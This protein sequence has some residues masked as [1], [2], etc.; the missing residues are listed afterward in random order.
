MHLNRM[1]SR[2]Q[3]SSAKPAQNCKTTQKTPTGPDNAKPYLITVYIPSI[4]RESVLFPP[5]QG[6]K[7]TPSPS[8]DSSQKNTDFFIFSVLFSPISPFLPL[9]ATIPPGAVTLSSPGRITSMKRTGPISSPR[10]WDRAGQYSPIFSPSTPR[11]HDRRVPG[12]SAVA[13]DQ[14]QHRPAGSGLKRNAISDS[15]ATTNHQAAEAEQGQCAGRGN[16]RVDE[17]VVNER[18]PIPVTGT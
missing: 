13:V 12:S 15:A 16:H 11:P 5:L 14:A 17:Y 9:L 4:V 8:T 3:T 6:V 2:E 18:V 7:P 10:Q 1:T